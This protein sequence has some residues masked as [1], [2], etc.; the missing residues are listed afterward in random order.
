V[1][2]VPTSETI[3]GKTT[4]SIITG[5]WRPVGAGYVEACFKVMIVPRLHPNM[6]TLIED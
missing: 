4:I 6:L 2:I 5:G 3:G 1:I